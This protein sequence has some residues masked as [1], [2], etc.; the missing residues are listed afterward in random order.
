MKTCRLKRLLKNT[1]GILFV[2][3][4]CL[5][6]SCAP[7]ALASSARTIRVGFPLQKGLAEIDDAG[8][9]SGY[10]YEYLQEIAQYTGWEYE[11]VQVPGSIDES[12]TE[13]LRML[14]A[15]EIDLLGAMV[16]SDALAQEYDYPGSSYGMAYSVLWALE[17][18]TKINESNYR[19]LD[20]LR[21][22][23]L[24]MANSRIAALEQGK[25]RPGHGVA[26][27][28]RQQAKQGDQPQHIG[29][30]ILVQESRSNIEHD[31]YH[32]QP[33]EAVGGNSLVTKQE[34]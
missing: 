9:Y 13:M 25:N 20:P 23:V 28:D 21:I 15:G 18:N 26:N 11:F 29:P 2:A 1:L 5:G 3:G 32:R 6:L 7:Q 31:Q 27:Q 8:D 24:D 22:A 17:E 12:L 30:H 14:Q 34:L 33:R 16:Y 19:T 10:T 4:L